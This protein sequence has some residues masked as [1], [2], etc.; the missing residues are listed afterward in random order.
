MTDSEYVAW[1]E[2]Q[3]R[4]AKTR[5]RRLIG[6]GCWACTL[7]CCGVILWPVFPSARLQA[8]N[9]GA[10]SN[11]K[12][13]GVGALMYSNDADDRFPN[14]AL[15]MD[16]LTPY[17]HDTGLF[18]SPALSNSTEFGFAFRRSLS[19]MK[20]TE[21]DDPEKNVLIFDSTDTRW[22]ANGEL[23]LLPRPG[24]YGKVNVAAF[25]DGHVRAIPDGATAAV[26]K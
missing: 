14:A 11:V 9:A 22:N 18:R 10:M 7:W 12:Q 25:A 20:I 5:K 4:R 21:I 19:G 13:L 23:T 16:M 24:R 15:W 6:L 1:D 26:V 2:L 17:V 3:Q 8:K